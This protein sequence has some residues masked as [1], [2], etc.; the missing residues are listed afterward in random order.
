MDQQT[1]DKEPE[2]FIRADRFAFYD[3]TDLLYY[4]FFT[5]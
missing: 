3:L 2:L 4:I 1:R 5:C